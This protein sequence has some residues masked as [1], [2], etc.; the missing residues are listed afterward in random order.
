M[1]TL[2]GAVLVGTVL[3][4]SPAAAADLSFT[5]PRIAESSGL[6][7]TG[8]ELLTVNDSGNEPL[9]FRVDPTTG[10]TIATIRFAETAVDPEALAPQGPGIVWVGDIGDNQRQ[11]DHVV[12]HRVEL[13]TGGVEHRELRYPDG[14]RDAEALVVAPDGRVLVI[15]KG[16]FGEVYSAGARGVLRRVGRVGPFVT[17]AAL[18]PDGRHVLVR[19]Y[20]NLHVYSF[21]DFAHVGSMTLP[22]QPQGEAISVSPQ[23]RI[24]ISSEGPR[25]RVLDVRL[26]PALEAA[27]SPTATASPMATPSPSAVPELP[28]SS[29]DDP[30]P[31]WVWAAL[32]LV[33]LILVVLVGFGLVRLR[34][35]L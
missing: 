3:A 34:N 24:R 11:R 14:P 20:G 25:Q 31:D 35:R 4:A 5:D 8:S 1:R 13:A 30:W 10:R 32:V 27:M 26:S 29:P 15:T 12:L 33:P 23:G 21:P 2:L 18:M 28:A 9:L 19:D 6:V 17:D 16:L 7:D 22:K